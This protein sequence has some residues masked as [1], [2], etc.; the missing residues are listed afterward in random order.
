VVRPRRVPVRRSHRRLDW[1]LKR[2][3]PLAP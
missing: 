2:Q 1:R 3:R